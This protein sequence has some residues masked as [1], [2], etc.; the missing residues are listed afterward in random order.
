MIIESKMNNFENNALSFLLDI[1][2]NH[3]LMDFDNNRY[4]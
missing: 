1:A 3:I 4:V 2:K